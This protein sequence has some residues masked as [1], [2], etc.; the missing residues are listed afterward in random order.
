MK[1]VLKITLL[2]I[3]MLFTLSNNIPFFSVDLSNTINNINNIREIEYYGANMDYKNYPVEI[4]ASYNAQNDIISASIKFDVIVLGDLIEFKIYKMNDGSTDYL[5]NDYVDTNISVLMRNFKFF[6]QYIFTVKTN[7]NNYVGKF[8][9]CYPFYKIN[10]DLLVDMRMSNISILNP[11]ISL[12]DI[13]DL[14]TSSSPEIKKIIDN[15]ESQ[16]FY[17]ENNN[18]EKSYSFTILHGGYAELQFY[19]GEDD[20]YIIEIYKDLINKDDVLIKRFYNKGKI[21]NYGIFL[22]AGY[23]IIKIVPL[24]KSTKSCVASINHLNL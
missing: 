1:K 24:N 10:T 21:N 9:F 8:S 17:I 2:F 4:I 3:I 7:D 16:L 14:N 13:S 11:I 20:E 19:A 23:D 18:A 22:N 5:Y 6:E 15:N 12:N